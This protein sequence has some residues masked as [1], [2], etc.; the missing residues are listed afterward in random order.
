MIRFL[1]RMILCVVVLYIGLFAIVWYARTL[2]IY[3]F[4][5]TY[6]TPSQAGEPR[7]NE[8]KLTTNDGETL[9]L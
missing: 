8:Y 2:L 1:K 6:V 5:S 9:I 3:P 4:D 7:L